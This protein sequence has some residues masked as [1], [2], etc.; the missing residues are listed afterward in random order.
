MKTA[1]EARAALV[2]DFHPSQ[3]TVLFDFE[4]GL[5]RRIGRSDLPAPFWAARIFGGRFLFSSIA[6]LLAQ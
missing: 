6:L 3:Q 5:F 4:W 1:S 2:I